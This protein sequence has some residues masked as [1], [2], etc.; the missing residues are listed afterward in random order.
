MY[1]MDP[2]LTVKAVHILSA[3]IL[4]GTGLGIAFFCW[5]GTGSNDD[6]AALFAARTTVI[7][8]L[9]FTLTAGIA[10]PLTGAWLVWQG[11]FGFGA[12]WLVATYALY[13]LALA[14]WLPVVWLQIRMRDML[15]AKI[16]GGPFDAARFAKLRRWW[17]WLGWPA[18]VGLIAV[19]HLMVAKPSW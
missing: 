14:C 19:F 1:L 4:F 2:Y 9:I 13:A 18:F 11:G 12:P 5:L 7:A 10:Q 3:T 17:F 15:A 16:A 8:D 6:R